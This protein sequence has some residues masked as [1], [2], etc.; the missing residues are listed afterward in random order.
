MAAVMQGLARPKSQQEMI[1]EATMKI[2]NPNMIGSGYIQFPPQ[3]P[4]QQPLMVQP[5]TVAV[6]EYQ[7]ER[8]GGGYK[9]AY[10]PQAA[11][12]APGGYAPQRQAVPQ[13][14]RQAA[15]G[16]YQ[17]PPQQRQPQ[18][19]ARPQPGYRP[20]Q[21]PQQGYPNRPPSAQAPAPQ[22]YQG[23]MQPQAVPQAR[24]QAPPAQA[25]P[26][27]VQQQQYATHSVAPPAPAQDAA[28]DEKLSAAQKKRLRKKMREG[29]A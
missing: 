3:R 4:F 22:Q 13:P 7:D 27:P 19:V 18:P 10:N 17:Q 6:Q 21:Q 14:Q 24:P 12:A 16:A 23:R 5:P 8:L 2:D 20:Q 1:D 29:K 9:P 11:P 26:A 25:P 28:G 15:P